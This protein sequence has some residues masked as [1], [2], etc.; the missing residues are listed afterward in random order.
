[1]S[2]KATMETNQAAEQNCTFWSFAMS[3]RL[4][5]YINSNF[6]ENVVYVC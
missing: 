1:M 2:E 3:K 5:A 4:K 6:E